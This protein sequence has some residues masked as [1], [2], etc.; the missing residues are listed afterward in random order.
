MIPVI[1][2][3][4]VNGIVSVLIMLGALYLSWYIAG[5]VSKWKYPGTIETNLIILGTIE[6]LSLVVVILGLIANFADIANLN[7]PLFLITLLVS[8]FYIWLCFILRNEAKE[9]YKV[10]YGSDKT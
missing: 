2:Q 10:L 7:V 6:C 5:T 1:F 3:V 9:R 8:G 4:Q